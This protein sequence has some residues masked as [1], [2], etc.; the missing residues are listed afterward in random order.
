MGENECVAPKEALDHQT[1][2]RDASR[3]PAERSKGKADS[4]L[5]SDIAIELPILYNYHQEWQFQSFYIK[6]MLM[7]LILSLPIS[8]ASSAHLIPA[9]SSRSVASPIRPASHSHAQ[10]PQSISLRLPTP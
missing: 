8:R 2:Q 4:V 1:Y 3:G 6:A 7:L 10:C 5:P 9:Q